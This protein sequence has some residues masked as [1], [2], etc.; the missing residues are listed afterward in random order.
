MKISKEIRSIII[1]RV[2]EQ[3]SIKHSEE[4]S[5]RMDLAE[6]LNQQIKE[7]DEMRSAKVAIQR[8]N[9]LRDRLISENEGVA[10]CRDFEL[11]DRCIIAHYDDMIRSTADLIDRI[12]LELAYCKDF[13]AAKEILAKYG[14]EL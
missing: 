14:I 1:R 9:A 4:R 12:I 5:R 10:V 7:S 6:K 8:L 13:D 2:Q 11:N 3:E